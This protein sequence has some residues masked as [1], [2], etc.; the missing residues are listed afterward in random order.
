[1]TSG[2]KKQK[3][4][5]EN[6]TEKKG[7]GKT[8]RKN[9]RKKRKSTYIIKIKHS[10]VLTEWPIEFRLVSVLSELVMK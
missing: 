7:N 5:K 8:I 6:G 3:K 1:M 2:E 10:S 4:E 9:K